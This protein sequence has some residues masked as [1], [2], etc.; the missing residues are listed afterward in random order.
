MNVIELAQRLIQYQTI[1]PQ[2]D[3]C[4]DFIATFL[5]ELGFRCEIIEFMG[6]SSYS[7]K[8]LYARIG[9]SQPNWCFAGHI[10]VVPVGDGWRFPPFS[11]HIEAGKIYGRGIVDM[12]GAVAAM[13]VATA[14]FI[15]QHTYDGSI[16]FLLTGDEEKDAINGTVKMLKH[17]AQRGEKIDECLVGEPTNPNHLGEM[18]K[19]GRRGSIT[20][21]LEVKGIQGHV[22]YPQ[23]A[24]NPITK[25]I[26][27]LAALKRTK[28]DDGNKNFIPSNLEIVKLDADGGATN[29]IPCTASAIFNIRFNDI[30]NKNLLEKWVNDICENILNDAYKLEIISAFDAFLCGNPRLESILKDVVYTVTGIEPILS[31]EGGT[32]DAR[33]IKD[34]ANVIEFGLVNKTAHQVDEYCNVIDLEQLQKIY[35]LLLT[36][37]MDKV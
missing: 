12:K 18:I 3:G 20:F 32:S 9:D 4:L 1:T 6:A 8:N 26:N 25:L 30:H 5:S 2:D 33:F 34:Y 10:D 13:M 19:N 14:E 11:G 29:V 23:N 35:Y 27:C 21:K 17:L 28:L 15:K 37:A 22:A 31:T 16:S 36:Q 24:D 7:V